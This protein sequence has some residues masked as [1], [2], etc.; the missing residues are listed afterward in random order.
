M[1]MPC[2]SVT[3]CQECTQGVKGL[4]LDDKVA[5]A[6][7]HTGHSHNKRFST[8]IL[9]PQRRDD[10]AHSGKSQVGWFQPSLCTSAKAFDS[11]LTGFAVRFFILIHIDVKAFQCRQLL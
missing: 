6:V 1:S 5:K 2:S 3:T 8:S 10:P 9:A 7:A 4:G 11:S